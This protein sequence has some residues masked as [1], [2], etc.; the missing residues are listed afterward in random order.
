[1]RRAGSERRW[2]AHKNTASKT[3]TIGDPSI[4]F[5]TV[6][7][8][9]EFDAR[10]LRPSRT[11]NAHT[12][13]TLLR[14]VPD[15][16]TIKPTPPPQNAAA[17]DARER[18]FWDGRPRQAHSVLGFISTANASSAAPSKIEGLPI[19][20]TAGPQPATSRISRQT[21]RQPTTDR[22][23]SSCRTSLLEQS[24]E[25][26]DHLRNNFRCAHCNIY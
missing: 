21:V 20:Q 9:A 8:E 7:I 5:F 24:I 12:A 3:E 15:D 26:L 19:H 4:L 16:S 18:K 10:D 1:M 17:P 13:E 25:L 14:G 23:T 11:A 2:L 6:Q 22:Q